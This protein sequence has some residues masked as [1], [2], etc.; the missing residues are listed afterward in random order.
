MDPD[1]A[2]SNNMDSFITMALGGS[3][4]HSDQ[5]GPSGSTAPSSQTSTWFLATAGTTDIYKTFGG[6][7]GHGHQYRPTC[8]KTVDTDIVLSSFTG[9]GIPKNLGVSRGHPHWCGPCQ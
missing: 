3:K 7:T 5:Y 8:S 4:V 1:M 2:L 9:L 6:S